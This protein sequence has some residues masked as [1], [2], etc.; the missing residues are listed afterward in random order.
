MIGSELPNNT[1]FLTINFLLHF[2]L[3]LETFVNFS[4]KKVILA[5]TISI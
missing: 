2:S 4:R 1:W 5:V 3:T